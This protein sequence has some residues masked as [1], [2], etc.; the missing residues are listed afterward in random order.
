AVQVASALE[1][2]HRAGII[3]RDIKPDNIMVRHDGIVK[4]LDFGIAKLMEGNNVSRDLEALPG[5]G[6]QTTRDL[7]IGTPTYMSPGDRAMKS[8]AVLPFTNA[9]SD[10]DMEYLSDGITENLIND[11]SRSI[12]VMPRNSV[13][14]YKGQD[15]EPR[16]VAHDLAVDAV[17]TG[18]V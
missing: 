3:H 4:V 8:V 12:K 11:L 13:F 10:P 18:R 15:A 7:R 1:V 14:H 2:A 9:S 16:R 6:A 17:V 5:S